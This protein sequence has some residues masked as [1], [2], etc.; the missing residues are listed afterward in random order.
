VNQDLKNRIRDLVL[1]LEADFFGIADLHP[2]LDFICGQGEERAARYPWGI[3]MGIRLQDIPVD[4]LPARD[5]EGAI[6]YQ[7]NSY[8]VVNTTLDHMAVRVANVLQ[9]ATGTSG[10][11][12][13]SR[14][15]RSAASVSGSARTG[16]KRGAGQRNGHY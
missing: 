15:L 8:D 12:K 16:R 9:R 10:N 6:L 14:V 5:Q 11:S 1:S 2:A 7:H 13:K 3:S 4:M